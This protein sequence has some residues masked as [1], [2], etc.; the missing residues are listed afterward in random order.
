MIYSVQSQMDTDW[1]CLAHFSDQFE[2]EFQVEVLR[3]EN[4]GTLHRVR[5]IKGECFCGIGEVYV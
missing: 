5:P 2:A 3:D 1:D 4:P